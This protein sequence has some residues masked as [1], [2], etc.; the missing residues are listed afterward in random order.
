LRRAAS[1]RLTGKRKG[2]VANPRE[3]ELETEVCDWLVAHG[4]DQ[5]VKV[6]TQQGEPRDYDAVRGLDT[7]ELLAFIGATQAEPWERLV[8]VYGG[9]RDAAQIGF[10]DRLVHELDARG[11]VDELTA[12]YVRV[13][14][15]TKALDEQEKAK[16][17]ASRWP[18]GARM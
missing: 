6:G 4:G 7:A 5:A 8:A 1:G 9:D 16:Y 13:A 11:T 3:H 18:S 15:G 14:N 10:E 12:F 2:R 17:G